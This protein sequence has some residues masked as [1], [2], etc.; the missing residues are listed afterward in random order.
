VESSGRERM[1]YKKIDKEWL[2]RNSQGLIK[3]FGFLTPVVLLEL[4][5]LEFSECSASIW[6]SNGRDKIRFIF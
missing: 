2:I 1:L 5:E 6:L 4:A 3:T